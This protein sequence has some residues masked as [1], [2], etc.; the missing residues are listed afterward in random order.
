MVGAAIM[1][2]L[3]HMFSTQ[4]LLV[5]PAGHN[6][7]YL[8][9]ALVIVFAALAR[10]SKGI[11]SRLALVYILASIVVTV[12]LLMEFD[13]LQRRAFFPTNMDVIIGIIALFVV[14][15]SGA[16]AFGKTLP[17]VVCAMVAYAIFGKYLPP[18]FETP[19]LLIRDQIIPYFSTGL[20]TGWG[21]YGEVVSISANFIF[22]LVL[23]GSIL[24]A[25]GG[26][27]FII[28]VGQYAARRLASGPAGVTVIA[29][30][31]LGMITRR[32]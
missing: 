16:L 19:D 29:D 18:P 12:Y 10:T 31:L 27:G 9:F 25:V 3:Y 5:E 20:G 26:A 17:I 4:Y 6:V 23:F 30:A 28:G 24:E 11:K 14:F 2:A 15:V 21:I 32:E 8:G 13:P 7:I 1:M 22:L